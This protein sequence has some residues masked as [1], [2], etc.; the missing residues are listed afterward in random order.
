M[1]EDY[2]LLCCEDVFL[3]VRKLVPSL[4]VGLQREYEKEARS[5]AVPKKSW[6]S[7]LFEDDSVASPAVSEE[8]VSRI[9]RR[10]ASEKLEADMKKV[11]SGW[12]EDWSDDDSK[13]EES[14]EARLASGGRD[15]R[16]GG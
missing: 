8:E 14:T 7:E 2:P 9:A 16:K 11:V 1:F 6:W 15:R 3:A 4:A 10:L 5:L 12:L 13:N